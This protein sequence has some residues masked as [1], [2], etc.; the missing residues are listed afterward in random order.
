MAILPRSPTTKRNLFVMFKFILEMVKSIFTLPL[1]L[2]KQLLDLL[3]NW[4]SSLVGKNKEVDV[5][6]LAP[7][8]L[9]VG[10][11]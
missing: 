10:G 4:F 2:A 9:G 8:G 5:L 6:D 3:V 7:Q 1:S 11:Q